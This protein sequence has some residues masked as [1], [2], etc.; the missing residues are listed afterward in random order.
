MHQ[1]LLPSRAPLLCKC[2]KQ[3]F[4]S[5][6]KTTYVSE[7]FVV[8]LVHSRVFRREQFGR[9]MPHDAEF[10]PVHEI[11]VPVGRRFY[12]RPVELRDYLRGKRYSRVDAPETV[13]AAPSVAQRVERF[14]TGH[15]VHGVSAQK[16]INS[17]R[18]R[19]KRVS[20]K[21]YMTHRVIINLYVYIFYMA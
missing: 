16:T 8:F 21:S 1:P 15:R 12:V 9:G 19:S 18:P 3:R 14:Q 7:H 5:G 20:T 17:R 4:R 2:A 11:L 6:T 10:R 13:G